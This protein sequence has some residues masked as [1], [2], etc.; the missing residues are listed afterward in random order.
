MSKGNLRFTHPWGSAIQRG[1]Y[2]CLPPSSTVPVPASIHAVLQALDQGR[3]KAEDSSAC[4]LDSVDT[5]FVVEP[6]PF[7]GVLPLNI[8]D[9]TS[10]L[11]A[12]TFRMDMPSNQTPPVI[13][14]S[15]SRLPAETRRIS[16]AIHS[17]GTRRG[18]RK[19]VPLARAQETFTLAEVARIGKEAANDPLQPALGGQTVGA[20]PTFDPVVPGIQEQRLID[21]PIWLFSA[22][23]DQVKGLIPFHTGG[24]PSR[25]GNPIRDSN[26]PA[27]P[28]AA[29]LDLKAA[30]VEYSE[31]FPRRF[32]ESVDPHQVG[33]CYL[34][35]S[36][37]SP[38]VVIAFLAR[39]RGGPR[40][41]GGKREAS[42][43][44]PDPARAEPSLRKT[45]PTR[46]AEKRR[47]A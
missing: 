12:N 6:E 41:R 10:V 23:E 2:D 1:R 15:C 4:P 34:A 19:L 38:D 21:V 24:G 37:Q 25:G 16:C 40:P 20:Y 46:M 42:G 3:A 36:L 47:G 30:I 9:A 35:F 7:P 39:Q 5:R 31:M 17:S 26:M 27:E 14:Y 33:L 45:A 18:K 29:R 44:F 11:G 8:E 32:V 28:C 22:L 43:P 13:L